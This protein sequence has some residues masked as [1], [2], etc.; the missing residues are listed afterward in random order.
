MEG[1]GWHYSHLAGKQIFGYQVFGTNISTGDVSLCYCLRRCCLE[2][3]SKIDRVVELLEDFPA[4]VCC[5]LSFQVY[6][7]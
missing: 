3:S 5:Y 2:N 1:T 7:V 4:F 6:F